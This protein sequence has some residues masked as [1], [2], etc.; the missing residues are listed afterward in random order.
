MIMMS[1]GI[2]QVQDIVDSFTG[3]PDKLF[4]NFKTNFRD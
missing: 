3:T 1:T 2:Q 4:E